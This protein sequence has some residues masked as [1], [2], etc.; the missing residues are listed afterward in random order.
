RAFEAVSYGGPDAC[1]D[2]AGHR[3][4]ALAAERSWTLEVLLGRV[5]ATPAEKP[6][7]S[8]PF[9]LRRTPS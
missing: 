3:R 5:T 1:R 7:F 4:I 2:R 6:S 8:L 9:L